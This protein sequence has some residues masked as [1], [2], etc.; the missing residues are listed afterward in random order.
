MGYF[1]LIYFVYWI[2]GTWGFYVVRKRQI[3]Y[4]RLARQLYNARI[5][6][7]RR[8][9]S[10]ALVKAME[11]KEYVKAVLGIMAINFNT[12]VLQFV[13]GVFLLAPFWAGFAGT[14]T[15]MVHA[16]GEKR[17]LFPYAV[18]NMIFA[19]AAFSVGGSVGM[20]VGVDWMFGE[21]EIIQALQGNLP[22]IF[23][24]LLISLI[25]LMLNGLIEAAGPIFFEIHSVPSLEAVRKQEH[26][27]LEE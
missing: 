16:F 11:Q 3:R 25:L 14:V 6:K 5:D 20:I 21:M 4:Q 10:S 2:F 22:L 1:V 17:T 24:G 27:S 9:P 23:S 15:G 12:V 7:L 8:S 26:L 19:F 18:A 13:L